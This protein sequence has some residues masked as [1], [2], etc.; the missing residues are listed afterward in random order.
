MKR[1]IN[2]VIYA[3]FCVVAL[4]FAQT[5]MAQRA[6]TISGQ[7]LDNTG[8]PMIGATVVVV[9]NTSVGTTT[10]VQGKYKIK[11]SVDDQLSFS[12]LGYVEVTERVGNRTT[13]N[14]VL[15]P[16]NVNI[17][18]VVVIGYGTQQKSDLTG[19]VTSV[20][21]EDLANTAVQSVDDA[22]QGRLA[23]VEIL[24]TD[25]EPGASASI[26]VRGTRSITASN[27]PLIVVDGVMDAVS[28][29]S[30]IDPAEIKNVTVLKDA[31]STAIYG[32][33]G[34]NGVII[35]T[36]HEA[37]TN[38]INI[39]FRSSFQVSTLPRELD[40]M[41]ASEF[42]AYRNDY[43][44]GSS[45]TRRL[46]TTASHK[47]RYKNPASYG[48][49]TDWTDVM[50]RPAFSQNYFLSLAGGS[51][52]TK[53]LFSLSYKDQNGI[54]IATGNETLTGRLKIDHTLFKWLKAG[55]NTNYYM[56]WRDRN[57]TAISGTGTHAVTNL[58]PMQDPTDAWDLLSD[59]G[60]NGGHVYNSPYLKALYVT[61]QDTQTRVTVTPYLELTLAKGLKLKSQFSYIDTRNE[62]FYYSPSYMPVASRYKRGGT[63]ERSTS[64][65]RKLNSETTLTYNKTVKK[66]HKFNALVGFTAKNRRNETMSM[67]GSGYL[68]DNVT[69]YNMNSLMDKRNLT[70]STSASEAQDMSVLGRLNY[71][72]RNRYRLTVTARGDGSSYFAKGHKWAFFPS[73]AFKWSLSNEKFMRGAKSWLSD[74]SVRISA[75][76]TGN[77][78]I[79]LYR[80]QTVLS[81]TQSGWFF[82]DGYEVSVY[83]A[84]I[85]NPNLTWEKT[86]AYNIGVDMSILNDRITMT[87]EAYMSYTKDL[88]YNLDNADVTGF[89]SRLANVGNTENKGVEFSFTSRNITHRNFQWTTDLTVSHNTSNVS[90]ITTTY[91]YVSTYKRGGYMIYGYVEGYP[92]NSLWGFQYEGVW[93]TQDEIEHNKISKTYVG[94]RIGLGRARYADVNHDGILNNK[95]L[96]YL[97]SADPIIY[98]GFNNTFRI[99]KNFS[100]GVFFTYSL[101]GRMYNVM[102]FTTMRGTSDS[103][104]DRRMLE[105]WHI[106]RNPFSDIPTTYVYDS[107]GSDLYIYDA[108][109]LRL[110]SINLSYNINLRKKTRYLRD[111][112]LTAS[113]NNVALITKFPG[114]DPDA[115]SN[116]RRIDTGR[117]P[118]NRTYSL[119]IQIRY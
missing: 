92:A 103:N 23:G 96:V 22:L 35:V 51:K 13:I 8:Q 116:G 43:Y 44:T 33:R 109:Y 52:S 1:I 3:S 28:N 25:G 78:S 57:Q 38:K 12:F 53:V 41:N 118:K 63:A 81:T 101:G 68:D 119:A 97:G 39:T 2:S 37:K 82:G 21:I 86:D 10:D 98:G 19:A 84:R 14:I 5:A 111:I 108:S 77:N 64:H 4:L 60:T 54:V 115:I 83:P 76:R 89:G 110:K 6:R 100:L 107:Y 15:N 11:A 87:L 93:H 50:L 9:G 95:D 16:E 69:A 65:Q 48:E 46:W 47:Q 104:K 91:G 30:D 61:D 73:A 113:V 17:N 42:A 18:E 88:L 67:S 70:S 75:G 24:S 106:S 71:S 74:L 114:Y 49:G 27:E 34:A 105:A 32:S 79:S 85:D 90:S 26:R 56:R 117:Y 29:F 58:S 20:N 7:V 59:G 80:S 45:S 40:M 66:R 99:Y 31:S 94:Y 62:N 112:Q 102:E 36:T 72:Y 55:I